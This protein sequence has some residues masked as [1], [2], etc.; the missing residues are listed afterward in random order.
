MKALTR[1]RRFLSIML[2]LAIVFNSVDVSTINASVTEVK[3]AEEIVDDADESTDEELSGDDENTGEESDSE[4]AGG[5]QDEIE[6]DDEDEETVEDETGGT[7]DAGDEEAAD[8]TEDADVLDGEESETEAEENVVVNS[9]EA[10]ETEEQILTKTMNG[11]TVTAAFAEDENL[12]E[13]AELVVSSE[14]KE[15][16]GA[17]IAEWAGVTSATVYSALD[18]SIQDA[19]GVEYAPEYDVEITLT[20]LSLDETLEENAYFIAHIEDMSDPGSITEAPITA[21]DLKE[22]TVSFTTG[23]FS[24]FVLTT[25]EQ[26]VMTLE[27]ETYEINLAEKISDGDYEWYTVSGLGITITAE[28]NKNISL[29][30][31]GVAASA[32]NGGNGYASGSYYLIIY[33]SENTITFNNLPEDGYILNGANSPGL[34]I[35]GNKNKI[36]L[37]TG[38]ELTI[39]NSNTTTVAAIDV[40][41]SENIFEVDGKLTVST[42]KKTLF[43]IS[44]SASLQFTGSGSVSLESYLVTNAGTLDI[45]DKVSV[46]FG[47]EVT[48]EGVMNISGSSKAVFSDDVTIDSGASLNLAESAT[49]EFTAASFY[50]GGTLSIGGDS[51]MTGT[52]Y[53]DE[54]DPGFTIAYTGGI[55]FVQTAVE[56]SNVSISSSEA[57]LLVGELGT[58][59]TKSTTF[60]FGSVSN[61]DVYVL[62]AGG[63]TF[64]VILAPQAND[65][66]ILGTPEGS[67]QASYTGYLSTDPTTSL[68]AFNVEIGKVTVYEGLS[69]VTEPSFSAAH[70]TGLSSETD[71]YSVTL[72]TSVQLESDDASEKLSEVGFVLQH[73]YKIED[74]NYTESGSLNFDAGMLSRSGEISGWTDHELTAD[75][76]EALDLGLK[77]GTYLPAKT[78]IDSQ[79]ADSVTLTIS[80]LTQGYIYVF[81]PYAVTTTY[82]TRYYIANETDTIGSLYSTDTQYKGLTIEDTLTGTKNAS[83]AV[84]IMDI[85]WPDK[86]EMT[87]G[88]VLDAITVNAVAT[89]ADSTALDENGYIKYTYDVDGTDTELTTAVSI[90]HDSSMAGTFSFEIYTDKE[91][92][93]EADQNQS[94]HYDAKGTYYVKMTFMPA[95][96][97]HATETKSGIELVINPMSVT[98][99]SN[100]S[101]LTDA[102]KASSYVKVYDGKT[103][104]DLNSSDIKLVGLRG[105]STNGYTEDSSFTDLANDE[106][107]ADVTVSTT[108][109]KSGSTS[110]SR[111]NTWYNKSGLISDDVYTLAVSSLGDMISGNY[112]YVTAGTEYLPAGGSENASSTL[113]GWIAQRQVSAN[114]VVNKK[115]DDNAYTS[116]TSV[117][118]GQWFYITVGASAVAGVGDSGIVDGESA[119]DVFGALKFDITGTLNDKQSGVA[120]GSDTLLRLTKEEDVTI[121]TASETDFATAFMGNYYPVVLKDAGATTISGTLTVT[122][123]TPTNGTNYEITGTSGTLNPN[124]YIDVVTIAAKGGYDKIQLTDEIKTA[125]TD[126]AAFSDNVSV[127]RSGAYSIQLYNSVTGAFTN[128]GST[129]TLTIDIGLPK[130]TNVTLNS[131]NVEGTLGSLVNK[132]TFGVFCKEKIKITVTAQSGDSGIATLYYYINGQQYSYTFDASEVLSGTD[133]DGNSIKTATYSFEIALDTILAEAGG[134]YFYVVNGAGEE[135]A[136][137]TV[138]TSTADDSGVK[139]LESQYNS[140]TGEY[141]WK[142]EDATIVVAESNQPSA[143]IRVSGT[144]G[145]SVDSTDE[146]IAGW[147]QSNGEITITITDPNGSSAGGSENLAASG[148]ASYTVS[149]AGYDESG[150]VVSGTSDSDKCT[151][152]ELDERTYTDTWTGDVVEKEGVYYYKYTVVVTDNAGTEFESFKDIYVDS[153]PPTLN[154]T[155]EADMDG[156]TSTTGATEAIDLSAVNA[157]NT[158]TLNAF[159]KNGISVSLTVSDATS[160]VESVTCDNSALTLSK[161]DTNTWTGTITANGTYQFTVMDK[162][163]NSTVKT[164]VV[165]GIDKTAPTVGLSYADEN[166]NSYTPG[167]DNWSS[168]AV[169]VT[170]DVTDTPDGTDAQSGFA[171]LTYSYT[172]D[173]VASPESD[174]ITNPYFTL[175]ASG[176]YTG[177]KVTVYDHAG[178][179]KEVIVDEPINIDANDPDLSVAATLDTKEGTGYTGAWTNGDHP[180]V[181]A[182]SNDNTGSTSKITYYITTVDPT[183]ALADDT[184]MA[185]LFTISVSNWAASKD[186]AIW[187]VSESTLT[188][189][190]SYEGTLYFAAKSESGRWSEVESQVI[191]ISTETLSQAVVNYNDST[192]PGA[193]WYNAVSFEI[194]IAGVEASAD[195]KTATPGNCITTKYTLSYSTTGDADTYTKEVERGELV[196]SHTSGF[197]TA[198]S[199]TIANDKTQ[200]SGYYKLDVTVTDDAGNTATAYTKT[201]KRDATAPEA[202]A[203]VYTVNNTESS[204]IAQVLRVLTFGIF[205]NSTVKVDITVSDEDYGSGAATLWYKVGDNSEQSASVTDKTAEITLNVGT[206]GNI[207]YWVED[208]AGNKSGQYNLGYDTNNIDEE[209]PIVWLLESKAP[210]ITDVQATGKN[211]NDGDVTITDTSIAVDAD[212]A[213]WIAADDG[214]TVTATID[215]GT[216]SGIYSVSATYVRVDSFDVD[217]ID[218]LATAESKELSG[219]CYSDAAHETSVTIGEGASGSVKKVY[220]VSE[221]LTTSGIYQV[222]LSAVDNATNESAESTLYVYVD[223]EMPSITNV[224]HE[225]EWQVEDKLPLK[226]SFSA[227]DVNSGV[228]SVT[229]SVS[230]EQGVT[231]LS[232]NYG[233]ASWENGTWTQ[234]LTATADGKSYTFGAML[235]GEYTITVTD[236]AGN[237]KTWTEMI[238]NIDTEAPT[239]VDA[240]TPVLEATTYETL[241]NKEYDPNGG[242]YY[243]SDSIIFT[244]KAADAISGIQSYKLFYES[245]GQAIE[246]ASNSELNGQ[247]EINESIEFTVSGRYD[248]WVEVTD[249]AG[250]T[251]T[252]EKLDIWL[253]NA[254]PSAAITR[255]VY[256]S[257]SG[258][259]TY[260][261]GTWVDAEKVVLTITSGLSVDNAYYYVAIDQTGSASSIADGEWKLLTADN[262]AAY[263][264]YGTIENVSDAESDTDILAFTITNEGSHTYHFKVVNEKDNNYFQYSSPTT[265]NI[266]RTAPSAASYSITNTGDTMNEDWYNTTLPTVTLTDVADTLSSANASAPHT[267]YYLLSETDYDVS[268]QAE[269][270]TGDANK[271]DIVSTLVTSS[272]ATTQSPG[273]SSDGVRYLYYWTIDEAGNSSAIG[274][275]MIKADTTAPKIQSVSVED[276]ENESLLSKIFGV[277][278]KNGYTV[279]VEIE[280]PLGTDGLESGIS[281]VASLTWTLTDSDGNTQRK[282]IESS[283]LTYTESGSKRYATVSFDITGDANVFSDCTIEVS[284]TDV[285]GNVGNAEKAT[286]SG[287]NIWTYSINP[288]A[289]ELDSDP[290]ANALNWI[291]TVDSEDVVVTA[292]VT[293]STAG[294]NTVTYEI[295]GENGTGSGTLYE[296]PQSKETALKFTASTASQIKLT[297]AQDGT[298]TVTVSA[299]TNAGN[300]DNKTITLQIDGSIPE[301]EQTY[302][303]LAEGSGWHNT[304]QP[305]TFTLSDDISGIWKESIQVYEGTDASG[306]LLILGTD[307]SIEEMTAGS[308]ETLTYKDGEDSKT[309]NYCKSYTVTLKD[310]AENGT[311]YVTATDLAGNSVTGKVVVDNIDLTKPNSVSIMPGGTQESGSNWYKAGATATIKT[312]IP[313]GLVSEITLYYTVTLDGEDDQSGYVTY[314]AT[315]KTV[316]GSAGITGFVADGYLTT[317]VSLPTDGKYEILA[318]AMTAA[319][320]CD[321]GT[322]SNTNGSEITIVGNNTA[323]VLVDQTAPSVY[324]TDITV[325]D[326]AGSALAS[327]ANFL[328]LGNFFSSSQGIT[329]TLS[330][331]DK[332]D[333]S[334]YSNIASA[335]YQLEVNGTK[336]AW[337]FVEAGSIYTNTGDTFT[338]SFDLLKS[339]LVNGATIYVRTTDA[340]GN[341]SEAGKLVATTVNSESVNGSNYWLIDTEKPV[342]GN[343]SYSDGSA[344]ISAPNGYYKS[345]SVTI[346]VPVSDG[347]N[348]GLNQA[349]WEVSYTPVGGSEPTSDS[350]VVKEGNKSWSSEIVKDDT[351]T[352]TF[353]GDG[354]YEVKLTVTDNATN[355]SDTATYEFKID[356]TAAEIEIDE[357]NESQWQTDLQTLN[358]TITDAFSGFANASDITLTQTYGSDALNSAELKNVTVSNDGKE[359]TGSVTITENGTYTLSW[360]DVAGNTNSKTIEVAKVDTTLVNAPTVTITPA[361]GTTYTN[362]ID[363]TLNATHTYWYVADDNLSIAITPNLAGTNSTN[364][365]NG[366]DEVTKY[367]LWNE[368]AGEIQSGVTPV[369]YA[370]ST[371]GALDVNQDNAIDISDLADGVWHLV[372]WNEDAAHTTGDYKKMANYY[373]GDSSDPVVL[374][375]DEYVICIDRKAPTAEVKNGSPESGTTSSPVTLAFTLTDGT[376]SGIDLS[377]LELKFT[378]TTVTN[379]ID[380][381]TITGNPVIT[382]DSGDAS[383]TVTYTVPAADEN[384]GTYTLSYKDMAGN[385]GADCVTKIECIDMNSLP[386]AVVQYGYT[387]TGTG[388]S[389]NANTASAP[390]KLSVGDEDGIYL[391][392]SEPDYPGLT[393]LTYSAVLYYPNGSQAEKFEDGEITSTYGT[394]S[395]TDLSLTEGLWHLVTTT[396]S[397]EKGD[398]I[399]DYYILID[400]TAP[401]LSAVTWN[402]AWTKNNVTVTISANDT[403]S[404]GATDVSGITSVTVSRDGTTPISVSGDSGTWT[405][406]A[407]TNGAYTVTVTDGAGNVTTE[408]YNVCNID[409]KAPEAAT[410]KIVGTDG[411]NVTG[412]EGWYKID[413]GT[414]STANQIWITAVEQSGTYQNAGTSVDDTAKVT[415]YYELWKEGTNATGSSVLAAGETWKINLEEGKWNLNVWVEDDAS[416]RTNSMNGDSKQW[417][418]YVD[419]TK[420]EQTD[421]SIDEINNNAPAKVLNFLSFGNF[422]N[423]GIQIKLTIKDETSGLKNL[424]YYVD[425]D[426]SSTAPGGTYQSAIIADEGGGTFT[427]TITFAND[428]D[429]DGYIWIYMVDEA[430]NETEKIALTA[431]QGTDKDS[432]RWVIDTVDPTVS[433]EVTTTANGNEGW[434]NSSSDVYPSVTATAQDGVDNQGSSV[435]AS[436]INKLVRTISKKATEATASYTEGMPVTV[437]PTTD[438]PLNSIVEEKENTYN[439]SSTDGDGVFKIVYKV[440]DNVEKTATSK[441]VEVKIDKTVPN[442]TATVDDTAYTSEGTSDTFVTYF[443]INETVDWMNTKQLVKLTASDETSGIT[444]IVVETSTENSLK[445]YNGNEYV[446]SITFDVASDDVLKV[447]TA[448]FYICANGTFTVTAKDVAGNTTTYKFTVSNV[449]TTD[450]TGPKVDITSQTGTNY[451]SDDGW[452]YGTEY[453]TI[454]ITTYAETD[455]NAAGVTTY[456]KLWNTSVDGEQEPTD[457][458]EYKADTPVNYP[459]FTQD[460]VY[461]LIVWTEDAAG[462]KTYATTNMD[463]NPMTIQVDIDS[464]AITFSSDSTQPDD[465]TFTSG[466]VVVT[467]SIDEKYGSG[468]DPSSLTL[469]FNGNTTQN[470]S[471]NDTIS[472]YQS[473]ISLGTSEQEIQFMIE[474]GAADTN[475]TWVLAYTDVAGNV[476]SCECVIDKMDATSR[477]NLPLPTP[478]MVAGVTFYTVDENTYY[479]ETGSVGPKLTFEKG[480]YT[481]SSEL[482]TT[483]TITS[484]SGSQTVYTIAN[485]GTDGASCTVSVDG[486]TPEG[487]ALYTYGFDGFNEDGE[488]KVTV[489]SKNQAGTDKENGYTY[490]IDTTAPTITYVSGNPSTWTDSTAT[491]NL[492]VEDLFGNDSA[493]ATSYVSGISNVTVMAYDTNATT[494]VDANWDSDMG[495][496]TFDAQSNGVYR[497]T[498]EDNV[499]NSHYLDVTVTYID[500]NAPE[501]A[502]VRVDGTPGNKVDE[503]NVYGWYV[504][505]E[506]GKDNQITITATEQAWNY[507]YN[508][509]NTSWEYLAEDVEDEAGVYTYINLYKKDGTPTTGAVTDKSEVTSATDGGY[510]I[511]TLAKD[512]KFVIN[513]AEGIWT[514]E[515]WTKDAAG[516]QSATTTATI[517]VD[518]TKPVVQNTSIEVTNTSGVGK[519]L[520]FLTF[521][522]FFN[523]AI[524]ITVDV[525]E[526][527]SGLSKFYYQVI[528]SDD[529]NDLVEDNYISAD[530]VSTDDGYAYF[531]LDPKTATQDLLEG[532]IWVYA[533]DAAGNKSEPV[534]LKV[535]RSTQSDDKDYW[536]IDTAFP[537]ISLTLTDA[538]STGKTSTDWFNAADKTAGNY[539]IVWATFEEGFDDGA[540]AS[541]FNSIVREIQLKNA[542]GEYKTI[543]DGTTILFENPQTMTGATEGEYESDY[544]KLVDDNGNILADG[545]YRIFYTVIDNAGNKTTESITVLIDTTSPNGTL[546]TLNQS[547]KINQ[548][549]KVTVSGLEDPTSG[550]KSITITATESGSVSA[551]TDGSNAATSLT[552]EVTDDTHDFYVCDNGTYTVTVTDNAGNVTEFASFM[553]TN[554]DLDAPSI[555]KTS[556]ALDSTDTA[557]DYKETKVTLTFDEEI[558]PVEDQTITVQEGDTTYTY[559]L[560]GDEEVTDNEDGTWS[561]V[562]DLGAFTDGDGNALTNTVTYTVIDPVT[563]EETKVTSDPFLNVDTTYTVTI[564]ATTFKDEAG[565]CLEGET[566]FTFTTKPADTTEDPWL[567][568]DTLEGITLAGLGEIATYEMANGDGTVGQQLYDTENVAVSPDY[569]EEETYYV[570]YLGDEVLEIGADGQYKLTEDLAVVMDAAEAEDCNVTVS[571]TDL[572]GEELISSI[573][574]DTV[575]IYT[576][577]D[578]GN[579]VCDDDGDP[580]YAEAAQYT[581]SAT[582]LNILGETYVY[583]LVTTDNYGSKTTYRYL[584][585]LGGVLE[586]V[587]KG[588]SADSDSGSETGVSIVTGSMTGALRN[589]VSEQMKQGNKVVLQMVASVPRVS[590]ISTAISLINGAISNDGKW[591][592]REWYYYDFSLNMFTDGELT[593][594]ANVDIDASSG[595]YIGRIG[596]NLELPGDLQGLDAYA[597]FYM[598]EGEAYKL[599]ETDDGSGLV[600]LNADGTLTIWTTQYSIYAVSGKVKTTASGTEDNTK[601]EHVTKT[602]Y[603]KTGGG[604]GRT[605][606]EYVNNVVTET[607]VTYVPVKSTKRSSGSGKSSGT[608]DTVSQTEDADTKAQAEEETTGE[609]KEEETE[610]TEAATSVGEGL[611]VGLALLDLLFLV[612]SIMTAEYST[613][614]Q[615]KKKKVPN[616]I[617]CMGALILFFVTQPLHGI[618]ARVDRWTPVF[619]VIFAVQLVITVLKFKSDAEEAEAEAANAENK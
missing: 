440:T 36:I 429:L 171:Y 576:L 194:T 90:L 181:L 57:G 380:A 522:N 453:P 349:V 583:I 596:I 260:E 286:N 407:E 612:G 74:T 578:D 155:V 531:D 546:G 276:C 196:Y 389:L 611:Q 177:L 314:D 532:Y 88:D 77:I 415:T 229:V 261:N 548:P 411:T 366:S 351:L 343:E 367:Q 469:T 82:S 383:V 513:L 427:A 197:T 362:E 204:M 377:S 102:M 109:K 382:G 49:A 504:I 179:S 359:I 473:L 26:G 119:D 530:Y 547:T 324:Y 320:T 160:G 223:S 608:V 15:E 296:D 436:G 85:T 463:T 521:G 379:A 95:T 395:D 29:I 487:Y 275:E 192:E 207:Q 135:S 161:T 525:T 589:T 451:N 247:K 418:I 537:T 228:A 133:S 515:V 467:F 124:V 209:N 519:L 510:W 452:Y 46:T 241:Q 435:I 381:T 208:S 185:D 406:T 508:K 279:T 298:T 358:F 607:T 448:K 70:Y 354:T 538:N 337:K 117:L 375:G 477:D 370:T 166:K 321:S 301:F 609:R 283:D 142:T 178:M 278:S 72:N 250:N 51:K 335:E 603:V 600:V 579:V 16:A 346:T 256:Y 369:E 344:A 428:T 398:K 594:L 306:T 573:I 79:T 153:T 141:T 419:E 227:S 340:A 127:N 211:A 458:T 342:I 30:Y 360:T 3:E 577:D 483:I 405:F 170:A 414:N 313:T 493:K 562:L 462:N 97:A 332:F 38:N 156:A 4:S 319:G 390:Q 580:L 22:G 475:G 442:L 465:G 235:N 328:G 563:E 251:Y 391:N 304:E 32:D 575:N 24:E 277:F 73:V 571:V 572:Y 252:S 456:Y 226:V 322:T 145:T 297:N 99:Q 295:T 502:S 459:V 318:G 17:L 242:I 269:N 78:S 421:I 172:L 214:A 416:N 168:T 396:S 240:D 184:P 385:A 619:A 23:S 309:A 21:I 526:E 239:A 199:A 356:S 89:D 331:T 110:V 505:E 11:V 14:D 582:D 188:F 121:S 517:Y 103:T 25:V 37:S 234:T 420:P 595:E 556:P 92:T 461:K 378:S 20:G 308:E 404:T 499:G 67:S 182:L 472:N 506:Q 111:A 7:E 248:M 167:A 424:Y 262:S 555:T 107:T 151:F 352:K 290:E 259:D 75:E 471:I 605:T 68:S 263:S 150:N 61:E 402:E 232:D 268:T 426:M 154:G 535:S 372:V 599:G 45:T 84:A 169:T 231:Y 202:M 34:T 233:V 598:H 443:D 485:D 491:I 353:T 288:P 590:T 527:T 501:N 365:K 274:K 216:G 413:T 523:E 137:Y 457:E 478:S 394:A 316:T 541:G 40:T 384:N 198:E 293:E 488:W 144:P 165:T 520:N 287:G 323:T 159:T 464:P 393:A 299:E 433:A 289:I 408:T 489:Y 593:E 329:I 43:N 193:D 163:G 468:I 430:G 258:S 592:N 130:I 534:A 271:S 291:S 53:F 325:T 236:Y 500:K 302:Q 450:P 1:C 441:E 350:L 246:W 476:H 218:G 64:A 105:D 432:N 54:V 35:S 482:T 18:I 551:S 552:I 581:I 355:E 307:Y 183:A 253:V 112:T 264:S 431:Q 438:D 134:V 470:T 566:S 86:I 220:W 315:T 173:G 586:T 217:V 425:N 610:T 312:Q 374:S 8:D 536:M 403:S 550:V 455:A 518:Q 215:D 602:E 533:V 445:S 222:T 494:P 206:S 466:S 294:I 386:D 371:G 387:T 490:Y 39:Q 454:D 412:V 94:G 230:G 554:M 516:N 100:G 512:G 205:G 62:P 540:N 616:D 19:E 559:T 148:I 200:E 116:D 568:A 96:S 213:T 120:Y 158:A 503:T 617:L 410:V 333:T 330:G 529:E 558:V 237:V 481:G 614:K 280:D 446:K 180:I 591:L 376:G 114:I 201:F 570:V 565:N 339:D 569:D 50:G 113:Y 101:T 33:G 486:G 266:D 249:V 81:A 267:M 305:V 255:T 189:N 80:G 574:A 422:F 417:T 187:D 48:N 601:T 91:C 42:K 123:D 140:E 56:V 543:T 174:K 564:P 195:E 131:V 47:G 106:K 83:I 496:F 63:N 334:N 549:Q 437:F 147:F 243:S 224:S 557:W 585:S 561:V 245:D 132:L 125:T 539:P 76:V 52:A 357:I 300:S 597:V 474:S 447:N 210:T 118:T 514:L 9:L 310:V 397:T 104:I 136:R 444:Q 399:A 284:A 203:V 361:D 13:D 115:T 587:T 553:V 497:V 363:K 524:R 129:D 10:E 303:T 484:P 511:A 157:G 87:Y 368:S 186:A 618:I 55:F 495:T 615:K 285:A 59:T 401:T 606:T 238:G 509:Q 373:A 348:S 164:V 498:A 341:V 108:A 71:G 190:G 311:Y 254:R 345:K 149:W 58:P 138:S 317:V 492:K 292:K 146:G 347:E 122:A 98:V 152:S 221:E 12:P 560:T 338:F 212:A 409:K 567:A 545:E 273:I 66:A 434:Y 31:D 479:S 44:E 364:A 225:N 139:E 176:T 423:K 326:K 257:N 272:G 388:D 542:S 162:A 327:I 5:S 175:A 507:S 584:V 65:F 265:V 219:T 449:D 392:L 282:T 244:L 128:V 604:S 93:K 28:D 27:D 480:K 126:L 2:T 191:K 588:H 281:G 460:G 60:E 69:R 143:T 6:S 439:F 544:L 336:S 528:D 270:I 400:N 613:L 41:G